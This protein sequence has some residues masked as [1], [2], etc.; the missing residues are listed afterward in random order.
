M[1]SD[2]N[3]YAEFLQKIGSLATFLIVKILPFIYKKNLSLEH[4]SYKSLYINNK[5][6]ISNDV[7]RISL[8]IKIPPFLNF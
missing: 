3:P 7:D 4:F 2:L 8:K 1:N 5:P 6:S